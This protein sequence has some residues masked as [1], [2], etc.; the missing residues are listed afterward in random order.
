M[1]R[2]QLM[3]RVQA[4][5]REAYRA[6]LDDLRP[7]VTAFAARHTRDA[8]A[9]DDLYQEV[10]LALHRA[11]HTYDPARPFEPWLFGIARH[12]AA[13]HARRQARRGRWEV[14]VDEVPDVA[15]ASE[16]GGMR[17]LEQALAA[18]PPAQREA[19]ELLRLEG[20]SLEQAAART[21]ATPGALK[22]RV[23]RAY[24]MLRRLLGGS[25]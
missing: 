15:G 21:G 9:A 11:R 24:R 2:A 10:L 17:A 4:G 19:V 14:V 3:A 13:D 23:H 20:L 16:G 6:L 18:L 12:V 7:L 1:E 22:V 5:D 8:A 25:T